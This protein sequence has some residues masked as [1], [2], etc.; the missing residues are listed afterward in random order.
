MKYNI[1]LRQKKLITE[2]AANIFYLFK[3]LNKIYV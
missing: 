1:Y 2:S 3:K